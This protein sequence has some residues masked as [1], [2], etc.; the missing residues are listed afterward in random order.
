MDD[1]ELESHRLRTDCKWKTESD[2][3]EKPVKI[4]HSQIGPDSSL[5]QKDMVSVKGAPH[6]Y[7][8]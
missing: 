7:N 1:R 3:C 2:P 6:L 5:L 4:I 8:W